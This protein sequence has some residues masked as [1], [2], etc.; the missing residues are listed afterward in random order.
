[1]GLKATVAAG[2]QQAFVAAGDLI[3]TGS[4]TARRGTAVYN[5]ATDTYTSTS[6]VTYPAVRMLRASLTDAEREASSVSVS[7]VKV[8]IP[9]TDLPG[10]TP[11]ETDTF[12]LDGLGYNVLSYRTVP[13]DSL[14]I[15][16][17]RE[18]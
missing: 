5:P 12:T 6:V 1:M 15:I 4:Y 13:G 17:A 14:W 8:L 10:V 18:K 3:S 9:A 2:V 16:I 7:D 11:D